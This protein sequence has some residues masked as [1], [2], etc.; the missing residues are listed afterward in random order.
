[1]AWNSMH[2]QDNPS[3]ARWKNPTAKAKQGIVTE[4]NNFQIANQ[5]KYF[6]LIVGLN[7]TTNAQYFSF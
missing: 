5:R 6:L 2:H 4:Y 3:K 7:L 1:M